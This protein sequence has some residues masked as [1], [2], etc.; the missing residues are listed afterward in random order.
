[1]WIRYFVRGRSFDEGQSMCHR[2]IIATIALSFPLEASSQE[3][4]RA[5]EDNSYFIEEAYNQE[6][7]VVQHISTGLYQPNT[8]D[9]VY[10]FTQEW[11]VGGQRHQLSY[12]IP[13]QSLHSAGCGLGDVALNYRYQLWGEDDCAWVSPRF[14]VLLP[15]GR[16]SD[17]LGSGVVG[18]QMNLPI[19]KRWTDGFVSHINIGATVLPNVEGGRSDG[20]TVHRTLSSYSFGV[21][22]IWLLASNINVMGE[23]LHSIDAEIDES[24]EVAHTSRTIFSPGFRVAID[25]GDLQIVPGLAL[26]IVFTAGDSAMQAFVYLSFEHP[27]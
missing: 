10:T 13:Y 15:T 9:F 14:S 26:P 24:G 17:G 21:S 6:F 3:F 27:F 18:V 1:M 11:P 12:T 19:S 23:I 7:R 2:F 25:I 16:S 22:G 8:K 4:S 5:I 20:V